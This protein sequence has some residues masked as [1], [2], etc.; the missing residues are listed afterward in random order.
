MRKLAFLLAL[1][2]LLALADGPPRFQSLRDNAEPVANLAF[3]LE[4]YLGECSGFFVS[5][6]CPKKAEAFREKV[7][8]RRQYLIVSE[9][10]AS[11]ISN[12][13][14]DP[15]KQIYTVKIDPTFHAGKYLLTL[16]EPTRLDQ[17]GEPVVQSLQVRGKT[18]IG[19]HALGS[20]SCTRRKRL[21]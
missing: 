10:E 20:R 3:F 19:W 16:G 6:D 18:P 15:A 4:Q 13:P 1:A 9:T 5:A 8:G 17:R 14:Y 12:G 11:M 21:R 7:N 2:P